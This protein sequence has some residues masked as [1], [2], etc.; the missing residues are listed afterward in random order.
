MLFNPCRSIDFLPEIKLDGSQLDLVEEMKLLGVVIRSDLKWKDNTEFIVKRAYKKL[1]VL[2]RL[3]SLG[4]GQ[5]KLLDLHVKQIGFLLEMA[6]PV[7]H[8]SLTLVERADIERVQK[9]ALRI[10]FGDLYENY[11]NALEISNLENL[12]CRR[13][14]LCLKFAKRASEHPKFRY[15][16]KQ[17]PKLPTRLVQDQY[18]NPI[19]RTERLMKG[20]IS[21]LTRLLNSNSKK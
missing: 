7:W 4:A 15:W 19:A 20:S 14:N 5:D 1:W 18:Y 17:K 2:R 11:Q 12:D 3:K 13:E 6:A 8:G 16:F 10:I 21:Y 9:A